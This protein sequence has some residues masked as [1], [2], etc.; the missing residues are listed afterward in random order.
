MSVEVSGNRTGNW[1]EALKTPESKTIQE[2]MLELEKSLLNAISS[3]IT[4]GNFSLTE[5]SPKKLDDSICNMELVVRVKGEEF[6]ISFSTVGLFDLNPIK[7]S[8]NNPIRRQ[9]NSD[10]EPK[11][12]SVF[13]QP[14]NELCRFQIARERSIG[15]LSKIHKYLEKERAKMDL[16]FSDEY[17]GKLSQSCI[18]MLAITIPEFWSDESETFSPGNFIFHKG[19]G[20]Q[21]IFRLFF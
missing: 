6:I 9:K 4:K 10:I 1:H 21:R 15:L 7:R 13:I 5:N 3:K 8:N 17:K 16:L 11:I 19:S 14:K 2:I 18:S 20:S 12:E